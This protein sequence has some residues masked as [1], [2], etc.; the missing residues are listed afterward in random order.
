MTAIHPSSF[1][2]LWSGIGALFEG[3][4][5]TT[6]RCAENPTTWKAEGSPRRSSVW[7]LC[8]K[9]RVACPNA[10][11]V[12]RHSS[13]SSR[14]RAAIR[15]RLLGTWHVPNRAGCRSPARG[16]RG[17]AAEPPHPGR[18]RLHVL[19][20]AA[21]YSSGGAGGYLRGWVREASVS[22]QTRRSSPGAG[23]S[24]P[25]PSRI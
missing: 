17:G 18:M 20:R 19:R 5:C 1:I 7:E 4:P 14:W 2:P 3:K 22:R 6:G 10:G 15:Q 16:G 9:Q 8:P 12:G 25:I 11:P 13:N 23:L 24:K 21:V